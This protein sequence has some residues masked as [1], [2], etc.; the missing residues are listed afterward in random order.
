MMSARILPEA[1]AR[2]GVECGPGEFAAHNAGSVM[3]RV[4]SEWGAYVLV[5]MDSG[6]IKQCHGMNSGPGIGW[7][8]VRPRP[9]AAR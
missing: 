4:E 1:G 6:E 5:M 3:C 2:I 8:Y 7:H 9:S